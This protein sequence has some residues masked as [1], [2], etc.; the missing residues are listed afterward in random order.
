MSEFFG[1]DA[2]AFDDDRFDLGGDDQLDTE[3]FDPDEDGTEDTD[4]AEGELTLD[5][6]MNVTHR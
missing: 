2:Q 1:D 4:R 6:W 3:S 5:A